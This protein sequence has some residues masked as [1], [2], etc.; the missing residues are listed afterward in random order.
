[1]K[2]SN[3]FNIN[4]PKRFSK[5]VEAKLAEAELNLIS[6]TSAYNN[7]VADLM[8]AKDQVTYL[9]GVVAQTQESFYE[10]FATNIDTPITGR[11]KSGT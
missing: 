1:M 7:Q 11:A 6:A 4:Y 8:Y 9:R 10:K 2:F 5:I 3:P